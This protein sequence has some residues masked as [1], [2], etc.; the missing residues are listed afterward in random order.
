MPWE[1][2]GLKARF[3]AATFGPPASARSS[4]DNLPP[5]ANNT[6]LY[7]AI[8]E[9]LRV[10]DRP[11]GVEGATVL[12]V[13]TDGKNDVDNRGDDPGL[14][15]GD[16]GRQEAQR[17]IMASRHQTWLVGVGSG[18]DAVE[19]RTLAGNK[20]NASV[21]EMDPGALLSLLARIRLSL[22]TQY[23]LVY[24]VPSTTA[25]RL[26]RRP[27][28]VSVRGDS[29][30][31]GRWRPPLLARP[32][33]RGTAD[34]ALL[35]PDIRL[36]AESG[37]TG[38]TDRLIVGLALLSVLLATYAL[39]WRLSADGAPAAAAPKAAPVP[40]AAAKRKG[41]T[42]TLRPDARDAPPRS[43]QDVTKDEAA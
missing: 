2:R 10:L 16:P 39:L 35:S 19:L 7:S 4:L 6:G 20:A 36:L 28:Q 3:D 17:L 42:S 22:A 43:A 1:S 18:V 41:G 23:T 9:G 31:L 25:A 32:P 21:V 5:V 24:G 34:S 30:L 33:Y 12:L 11:G 15:T 14:L 13:L 37:E 26:G 40:T 27:V 38:R 29:V 8:A